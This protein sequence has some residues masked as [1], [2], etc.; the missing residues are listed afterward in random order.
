M[1]KLEAI[2][3]LQGRT[4]ETGVFEKIANKMSDEAILKAWNH[5]DQIN[6]K[7]LRLI[8]IGDEFQTESYAPISIFTKDAMEYFLN[9]R[10]NN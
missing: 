10:N 2:Q 4:D 9:N 1:T 3:F 7:G 6:N 8:K 5:Q